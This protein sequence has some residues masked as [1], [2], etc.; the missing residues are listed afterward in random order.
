MSRITALT[1]V[2]ALTSTLL[3]CFAP[4]AA[5]RADGDQPKYILGT[6][7]VL[8]SPAQL[9]AP[10]GGYW[11]DLLPIEYRFGICYIV[12][13]INAARKARGESTMIDATK[14]P[15]STGG[16]SQ[17]GGG[18]EYTLD[19]Q[20]MQPADVDAALAKFPLSGPC[21]GLAREYREVSNGYFS[22]E[23]TGDTLTLEVPG[24]SITLSSTDGLATLRDKLETQLK[25]IFGDAARFD[26]S[27]SI[28]S[29]ASGKP[30]SFN[31]SIT[32][33]LNGAQPQEDEEGAP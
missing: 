2:A 26:T 18:W 25:A 16:E 29:P 30:A 31:A 15:I 6:T 12:D 32:V 7:L 3:V 21:A 20:R 27:L 8:H 11:S 4:L 9:A 28:Y 24:S 19:F 33:Y 5:A 13:A 23:S 22:A 1:L 17:V 14:Y 10:P